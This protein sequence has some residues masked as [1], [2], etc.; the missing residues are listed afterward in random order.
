[1]M[2]EPSPGEVGP[3][4]GFIMALVM[5]GL[6]GLAVSSMGGLLVATFAAIIVLGPLLIA[7]LVMTVFYLIRGV[8]GRNYFWMWG[9]PL[10]VAGGLGLI[11][12]VQQLWDQYLR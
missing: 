1:M 7:N 3:A 11:Y 4:I 6:A 2:K 12:G 9:Q 10:A 5:L 8:P